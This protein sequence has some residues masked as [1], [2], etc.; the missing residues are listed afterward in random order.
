MFKN[1][2]SEL[3]FERMGTSPARLAGMKST[4]TVETDKFS[5]CFGSEMKCD[6]EDDDSLFV[7]AIEF[8]G[9]E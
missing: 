8:N 3:S 9:P 1:L 4:D 6:N 7:D 2:M 5:D